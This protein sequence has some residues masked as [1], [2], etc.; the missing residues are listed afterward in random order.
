[1]GQDKAALTMP[2]GHT[3]LGQAVHTL[4]AA[5][6]NEILVS[7]RQGQTYGLP[8]TREVTDPT[9]NCGPLGGLVAALGATEA[10]RI[11][12]LAVDLPAMTDDYLR[13][14]IAE[15]TPTC[16][17]VPMRGDFFE[18]L[19]AVYPHFAVH[20]AR[21]ALAAGRLSLQT[22][23]RELAAAGLIKP[24][25]IEPTKTGLFANWNTSGDCQSV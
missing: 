14:L 16:G 21:T 13:T 25:A 11:I 6:A 4:R 12:V 17:I 2:N 23:I 1:M 9:E 22:W 24:T 18:P 20:S 3:L 8:G 7:V 5:G 15:S 19:A 10:E